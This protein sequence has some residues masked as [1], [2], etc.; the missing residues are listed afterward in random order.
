MYSVN[1]C[2]LWLLQG[3]PIRTSTDQGSFAAPRGF[4]QLV[5]S[6]FGS[7]CQGILLVLFLTWP[8]SNLWLNRTAVSGRPYFRQTA[9]KC[10]LIHKVLPALFAQFVENLSRPS[11]HIRFIQRLLRIMWVPAKLFLLFAYQ[12]NISIFSSK[13]TRSMQLLASFVSFSFQGANSVI[14]F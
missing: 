1:D 9:Q 13:L 7:R 12:K 8:F 10:S 2:K 6:F 5:A 4:S 11:I 3:F 14:S